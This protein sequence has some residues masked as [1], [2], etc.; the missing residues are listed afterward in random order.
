MKNSSRTAINKNMID[1]LTTKARDALTGAQAHAL[2]NDNTTVESVH[3]FDALLDDEDSGCSVLLALAGGDRQ[4]VQNEVR[5]LIDALPTT[6]APDG[7]VSLSRDMLRL[8]N[9]S[10][11]AANA[12]QDEYIAADTLFVIIAEHDK[13]VKKL[14]QKNGVSATSLKAAMNQ[15]RGGRVADGENAEAQQNAFGKY[16][17]DLTEQA[18]SGRL[19]PVIGR[20]EEIRRALHVLQRRTKN[21][22][23]IIGD[24]GV[25]K[26]A[27]VEGLAQ[28]LVSGEASDELGGK[29]ILA[30]DIA[31]LLAGAKY[32]GDFEERLKAVLKEIT[33]DGNIILF[34][35]ELHTLVGAGASGGTVDAANMLK[36]A[37]ARGELRCIGATTL[38]EYRRHIE[39]DAALER[40]FQK[41]L[42]SEPSPESAIAILRGLSGRYEAYHGVRITDPAIVAAVELSSRYVAD[43]QLPDKAID[44]IDEAA[45][46][47]K[48]EA[49]SKP[50][51]L[52]RIL[53][54]LVQLRIE[55]IALERESD[56]ESQK[57]L[58]G[59][60]SEIREQEKA[61]AD[62]EEVW[63]RERTLIE[64]AKQNQ[65]AYDRLQY[66]MSA[67]ERRGD[68]Q[69]LAQIKNGELPAL[70]DA[71]E[72]DKNHRYTLLKTF[73]G[74]DEIAAVVANATGIPVANLL[75]DERCKL[76][77]MEDALAVRIVG[78][79]AAVRAVSRV[80][81]RARAGL[82]DE[83]HPLGV[84]LFLGP[85]GVGKTEL[86]KA[87]AEFLFNTEKRLTRIDMSEYSEMHSVAR[88]IGAPPGYVGFDE[89]GQLTEAV[90][91][92]PFSVVLLDEVE[93]AH[94][95]V[96]N[97]LL[98]ALDDGRLTD[99]RGRTVDFKNTVI[100][101]TSNLASETIQ[102]QAGKNDDKQLTEEVLVEVRRFFRPEFFNRIDESIVFNPLQKSDMHRIVD[103]QLQDLSRRLG[104]QNLSL[105]IPTAAKDA[106][107]K[108]GFIPELGARPLKRLIRERVES[109]LAELLL[110]KTPSE[111]GEI[112]MQATGSFILK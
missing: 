78:Q 56:A 97:V 52:D 70:R 67:V 71:I 41:I 77:N 8:L 85:T 108:D 82:S 16:T 69:R 32:R 49:A 66:E 90:R 20:D 50:E 87:L 96:F 83:T 57:R 98:Q 19:D 110:E 3:V 22:P 99:G 29:K 75:D 61:A 93:K 84:F 73:I 55:R 40:R 81:R 44:L 48:M 26:T 30:L 107:A 17:I 58:A 72:R 80:I 33:A 43:R 1:K 38:D 6:S 111:G 60:R 76:L 21:N 36:P 51:A 62:L 106:L 25:G 105:R 103:I 88:L 101:M 102:R 68:W 100:I 46:R 14:L 86:C 24:P 37:L 39:K 23:V 10:Y 13:A 5:A 54:R 94:P 79:E 64:S 35:D 45:A 109:P 28:R 112:V 34:I 104:K 89:G 65:S 95:Q 2:R 74:A 27:I 63:Q 12:R 18:R 4:T 7:A 47:I 92:H 15:T 91:H 42:V 53:R 31:A 11:K 9:L 59:I